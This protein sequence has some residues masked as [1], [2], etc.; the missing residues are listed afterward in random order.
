VNSDLPTVA[1]LPLALAPAHAASVADALDSVSPVY[2]R[3][4]TYVTIALN[5]DGASLWEV[6]SA[7]ILTVVFPFTAVAESTLVPRLLIVCAANGD[8]NVYPWLVKDAVVDFS[9]SETDVGVADFAAPV[10]A[11]AA[12]VGAA[13]APVGAAETVGVGLE[14]VEDVQPATEITMMTP[15]N[16]NN[17]FLTGT[18]TY[19]FAIFVIGFILDLFLSMIRFKSST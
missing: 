16:N 7:R 14:L 3:P 4:L 12:P 10:C 11:A 17:A 18:L 19:R 9:Q 2:P 15:I 1:I 5:R 8:V 6:C 13:A